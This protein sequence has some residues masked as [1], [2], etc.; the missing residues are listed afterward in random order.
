MS[1]TTPASF[2][3]D[4]F[5]KELPT[6][7]DEA[8]RQ[9]V[10]G[11]VRELIDRYEDGFDAEIKLDEDRLC[12]AVAH[13]DAALAAVLVLRRGD[14]GY[15]DHFEDE[16]S[17]IEWLSRWQPPSTPDG[18]AQYFSDEVD[19]S[20]RSLWNVREELERQRGD[21]MSLDK[22]RWR[23]RWERPP[24]ARSSL[25]RRQFEFI[26][27][28]CSI[29]AVHVEPGK[30]PLPT[31]GARNKDGTHKTNPLVRFVDGCLA[32]A[33]GKARPE[34][35]TVVHTLLHHVRQDLLERQQIAETND[36]EFNI[37]DLLKGLPY[38]EY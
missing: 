37:G 17:V 8:T 3:P 4:L 19:W 6:R 11:E 20:V 18:A 36:W 15:D 1:M 12:R 26:Y 24:I 34:I 10:V 25:E 5:L 33:L 16:A 32:S 23:V 29:W 9:T 2:D 13:I 7:L 31:A 30:L 27:G 38:K 14:H 22:V 28:A 21:L 35:K